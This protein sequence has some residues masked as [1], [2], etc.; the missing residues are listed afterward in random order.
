M[1]LHDWTRVLAGT[2]HA[3]HTAWIAELQGALNS[4]ILPADFYALGEQLAGDVGPDV[5]T[6]HSTKPATELPPPQRNGAGAIAIAE[7]PPKVRITQQASQET[8]YYL[9]KQ[10]SV[11][12]RHASG[13]RV[14][15]L[16]EI[17]SPGNKQSRAFL[18]RFLNKLL[19]AIQQGYHLLVIDVFAAGSLDPNGI[20]DKVWQ[21][22]TGESFVLP[23]PNLRTLVAYRS[24]VP[25]TAYLEFAELG[26]PL[27]A[28]PLC[29]SGEEYVSVPLEATYE[30]A[31]AKMPRQVQ[32]TLASD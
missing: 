15:A 10:R 16:I 11:V 31:L 18:A 7:R 28:M 6:L 3:F 13:D 21:D 25:P 30:R 19:A 14:V 29:I 5:L 32:R 2:F 17:V 4:G 8:V 27:P 22:V 1:P 9:A 24:V 26:D 20:H 12:I 23:G